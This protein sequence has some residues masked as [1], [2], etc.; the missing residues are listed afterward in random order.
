MK[1]SKLI[2]ELEKL[3]KKHGDI[4]AKVQTMTHTFDPD[5]TV[6]TYPHGEKYL[7]LN[8]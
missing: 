6:R 2:A 4:E 3:K 5:I 8:D 1:I 7:V